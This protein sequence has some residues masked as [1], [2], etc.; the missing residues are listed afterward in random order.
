MGEDELEP[1]Q[2]DVETTEAET[3]EPVDPEMQR[4]LE[5]D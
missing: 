4:T 1:T 3:P 5:G 2:T